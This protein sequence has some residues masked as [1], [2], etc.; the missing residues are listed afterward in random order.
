MKVNKHHIIKILQILEFL[1]Y[2]EF[3]WDKR[4]KEPM[5][6]KKYMAD[7][8]REKLLDEEDPTE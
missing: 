3:L 6:I 4:N 1:L 5:E 8:I 2:E 7:L